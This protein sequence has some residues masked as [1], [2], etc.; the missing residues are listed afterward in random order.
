MTFAV[1]K[2]EDWRAESLC[3]GENADVFFPLKVTNRTIAA[4]MA[5]C[6][7]C[8]VRVQCLQIAVVYGYDGIWGG[9]TYAQRNYL[10]KNK[11]N[12]KTYGFSIDDAKEMLKEISFVSVSVRPNRRK[13]KD[14]SS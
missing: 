12:N 11:F 1:P 7:A 10:V 9:S 2:D 8:P 4:A 6:K 3:R 14:I 5:L 13:R